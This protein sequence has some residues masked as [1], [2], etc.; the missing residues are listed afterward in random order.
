MNNYD[1]FIYFI[2]IQL[3]QYF[4]TQ[5]I[6]TITKQSWSHLQVSDEIKVPIY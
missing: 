4:T 3:L 1:T 5:N 2:L 6:F